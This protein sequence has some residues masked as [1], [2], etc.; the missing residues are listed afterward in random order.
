MFFYKST[1]IN[2]IYSVRF[3]F[4]LFQ[5]QKVD[6]ARLALDFSCALDGIN[7]TL[8]SASRLDYMKANLDVV[9]NGLKPY[10]RNIQNYIRER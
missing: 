7:T 9:V 10:E 1:T 3:C 4:V 5:E 6:L 8:V 2:C